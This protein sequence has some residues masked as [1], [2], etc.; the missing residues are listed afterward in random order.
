MLLWRE[1]PS[2]RL[3][4][5]VIPFLR[6]MPGDGL[7]SIAT[8]GFF[9][10][11][12]AATYYHT[13]SGGTV[14]GSGA[15]RTI[16]W[17]RPMSGMAQ[18]GGAATITRAWLRTG[19]GEVNVTGSPM[20]TREWNRQGQGTGTLGGCATIGAVWNRAGYGGAYTGGT[21]AF[22]WVKKSTP[23][24]T[25]SDKSPDRMSGLRPKATSRPSFAGRWVNRRRA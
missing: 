15:T 5:V 11:T 20:V 24:R 25:V 8:A 1:S 17:A 21:A 18:S 23:K 9:G 6:S 22:A 2:A 13:M 4:G 10:A 16:A 3:G 7:P 14:T 12:Q 19:A